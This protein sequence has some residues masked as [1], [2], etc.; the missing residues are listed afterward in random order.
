ML[1][2]TIIHVVAAPRFTCRC[3][4]VLQTADRAAV[5]GSAKRIPIV[6]GVSG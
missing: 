3:G 6:H 1:D 4:R 5:F 2:Q